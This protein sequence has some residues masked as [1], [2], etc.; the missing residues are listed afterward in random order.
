MHFVR[1]MA[2]VECTSRHVRVG[3]CEVAFFI[4]VFTRVG[5]ASRYVRLCVGITRVGVDDARWHDNYFAKTN[6]S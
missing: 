3:T 2:C 1:H 4:G 6:L 5:D